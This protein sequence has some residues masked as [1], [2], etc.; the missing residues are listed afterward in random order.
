[1]S[2]V[3]TV[4]AKLQI[5]VMGGLDAF[6][7]PIGSVWTVLIKVCQGLNLKTRVVRKPKSFDLLKGTTS[8]PWQYFC[9]NYIMKLPSLKSTPSKIAN[10]VSEQ[11]TKLINTINEL[12]EKIT[13]LEQTLHPIATAVTSPT[14]AKIAGINSPQKLSK[15][16]K[17]SVQSAFDSEKTKCEMII[18]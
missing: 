8:S 14:W 6:Y 5:L 1:M 18:S 3:Q 2:Y 4:V 13:S 9:S 15:V 11:I 17:T 10:N 12:A 16:V 7:V